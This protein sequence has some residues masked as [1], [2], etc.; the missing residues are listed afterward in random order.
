MTAPSA[1]AEQVLDRLRAA[2]MTLAVAESLT[3]GLLIDAFVSVPGASDVLHGG[4]VAYATPVKH[5]VLGVDAALLDAE[6]PVHPQVAEQMARGVRAALAVDGRAADA[7]VATTGVAGPGDQDGRP[8]GTV[9]VAAAIG[10]DVI[11]EGARFTGD[12]AAVRA[13]TVVLALDTLLRALPRTE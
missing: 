3:G 1:T 7:G 4:L 6:G 2:G 10:D 5:S 9:W 8:A 12:R 13:A 11:V